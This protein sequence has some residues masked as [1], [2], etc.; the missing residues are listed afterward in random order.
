MLHHLKRVQ[1]AAEA[2]NVHLAFLPFRVP[3]LTPCEDL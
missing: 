1:A 2:T 3:E